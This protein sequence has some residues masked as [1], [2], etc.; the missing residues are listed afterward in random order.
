MHQPRPYGLFGAEPE[1]ED[2]AAVDALMRRL[3]NIKTLSGV[4]SLKM[5][6]ALPGGGIAT[7][8]SMGGILKVIV[9]APGEPPRLELGDGLAKATIPMFFSGVITKARVREGE[10]VE[11]DVT[12]QT[13]KRLAGYKD[14]LGP[15]RLRLQRFV[16]EYGQ[17]F[18]EFEPKTPTIYKHTQYMQLRPSWYSG[19]MAEVVQIAGGYGRQDFDQLPQT[20]LETAKLQVP[21]R[22]EIG[23]EHEL[24]NMRLPGYS[25]KP[26]KNGQTRFGYRHNECHGVSFDDAGKP[27]LLQINSRGVYAMPLPMVPASTTKAFRQWAT[28][29]AKDD[30]IV[31]MLDRYGGMPS[32]EGFPESSNVFE[33]WRRAG[34]IIKLCETAD[35]YDHLAYSSACGWSFNARGSE[36]YNTCYDYDEDVG[37]AYGLTYKMALALGAATFDGKLRKDWV[38][39]DPAEQARLDAYLMPLYR[40]ASVDGAEGL[41]VK[42]KLRRI[43]AAELLGR[44]ADKIDAE[45][46]HWQNLEMEP[47]APHQANVVR[48]NKGWLMNSGIKFAEPMLPELGLLTVPDKPL[49]NWKG[50]EPK[51]D[52]I[53]FAYHTGH[54]LKVVK[55]FAEPRSHERQVE[56]NFEAEMIIGAWEQ[57]EYEGES[58]I[59]GSFYTTDID[60]REEVAPREINTKLVG[61]DKGYGEIYYTFH[62]HFAMAGNMYRWRHYTHDRTVTTTSNRGKRMAVSVPYMCRD[63]VIYGREESAGP[64]IVETS[65]GMY[66]MADPYWYDIWTYSAGSHWTG[67]PTYKTKGYWPKDG[68]PVWCERELINKELI[69]GFSDSGPWLSPLQDVTPIVTF[70]EKGGGVSLSAGGAPPPFVPKNTREEKEFK[71]KATLDFSVFERPGHVADKLSE[72]YFLPSP[73]AEGVLF[74]VDA[75][76]NAAGETLYANL[77]EPGAEGRRK[78]FGYCKLADHNSAH[79]F[80]GVINE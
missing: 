46:T 29:E 71:T 26:P 18:K 52:T 21:K 4:D 47:I 40:R 54:D 17:R 72:S 48:T 20:P 69:G 44:S 15:E 60:E 49:E 28:E 53:V 45:Y 42:Y 41:A 37:L 33:A 14:Q 1:G 11:M 73:T 68:N 63:S 58:R 32:G 22:V 2:A 12:L 70:L 77:D 5:T 35:F 74:Y 27:W 59:T 3:G 55:H 34:V 80:I 6:R 57:T 79:H 7:A 51:R 75:I 19:A 76:R 67:A 25:G 10:A 64:V 66:S 38:R 23:I 16:I 78:H 36:A 50:P 24:S 9:Q 30:E 13:R 62:A 31:W 8:I 61:K 39:E 65:R 56:G 43:P